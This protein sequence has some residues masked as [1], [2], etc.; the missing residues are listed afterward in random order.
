MAVEGG[1]EER[2]LNSLRS[3]LDSLMPATSNRQFWAEAGVWSVIS[4]IANF[5]MNVSD[6]KDAVL[7]GVLGVGLPWGVVYAVRYIG[8][9]RRRVR[10]SEKI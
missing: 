8:W 3:A 2:P 10:E 6:V 9:R 4:I 7:R 1:G 5:A